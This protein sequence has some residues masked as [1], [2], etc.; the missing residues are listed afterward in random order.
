MDVPGGNHISC[1]R[2]LVVTRKSDLQT[3]SSQLLLSFLQC[4]EDDLVQEDD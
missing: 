2:A 1:D 4:M 3:V